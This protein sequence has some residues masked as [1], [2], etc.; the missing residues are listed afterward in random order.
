MKMDNG[1]E[2]ARERVKEAEKS[3]EGT[4]IELK[5]NI[6]KLFWITKG[7]SKKDTQ[8][9]AIIEEGID[10]GIESMRKTTVGN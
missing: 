3:L 6:M 7:Y 4:V 2:K 8:N 10:F 1:Y 5:K 9:S